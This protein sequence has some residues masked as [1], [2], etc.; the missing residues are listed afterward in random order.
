MIRKVLLAFLLALVCLPAQA[1]TKVYLHLGNS[2][3][4][5]YQ[6]AN[7][8]AG[9]VTTTAV[10]NSIT[11]SSADVQITASA[12]GSVLQWLSQPLASGVTLNS[13]ETCNFWGSENSAAA[14]AAFRCRVFKYTA[15][16][17]GGALCVGQ[18][19]TE[20]TTSAATT[21]A[22]CAITST[23]FATGDRIGIEVF[24]ENCATSGCP[25]GSMASGHTVTL[26]YDGPTTAAS[27]DVYVSFTEALTFA[28]DCDGTKC[29]KKI[30]SATQSGTTCVI[31]A[32]NGVLLGHGIVPISW[33][34]GTTNGVT[35]TTT[36][37]AGT[38]NTYNKTDEFVGDTSDNVYQNMGSAYAATALSAGGT[39]T[40]TQ[41]GGGCV[42][43][44]VTSFSPGTWLDKA[45]SNDNTSF[46]A[47]QASGTTASTAHQPNVNIAAFASNVNAAVVWPSGWV[48]LD[49]ITIASRTIHV[50]WQR[51]TSTGTQAVTI[52]IS[53]GDNT[54]AGLGS[55]M[56]AS[57]VTV[58]PQLMMS[59]TGD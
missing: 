14:N 50:G 1:A 8:T 57:A 17:L 22:S 29:V 28:D 56:E 31:T 34:S 49:D 59:G 21:T 38:P 16:A 7:S 15:G 51:V 43:Y 40:I 27:G 48:Q 46:A 32:P 18:V 37:N 6:R 55:Y 26:N 20:L 44:D 25:T 24:L 2:Y 47:S 10:T 11:S 45:V 36:D 13:T 35:G 52:T 19:A 30:A 9:L 23:V 39:I 53:A 58:I 12:G 4:A 42:A 5:T 54:A 41:S 33:A 3:I